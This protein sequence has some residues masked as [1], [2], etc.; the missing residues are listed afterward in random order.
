MRRSAREN[1]MSTRAKYMIGFGIFL[2]VCGL[3]GWAAAGFT[4]KA[5]TAL[6]SGAVCG[7]AMI[8]CGW[9]LMRSHAW[10]SAIGSVAGTVFPLLFCTVFTWRASIGWLAWIDGQPKFFVAALLSVMAAVSL[11]TF[12]VLLKHW[13]KTWITTASNKSAQPAV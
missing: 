7:G 12:T 13:R 11:A 5:K 4:A 3:F 1:S 2:A 8:V 9:L 6:M 10:L